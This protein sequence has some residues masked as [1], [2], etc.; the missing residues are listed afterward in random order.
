LPKT[1][2]DDKKVTVISASIDKTF[3]EKADRII[4]ERLLPGINNRSALI[5]Y[6]LRKVFDELFKE[7]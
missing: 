2:G 7:G 1:K 3:L 6:A 4:N 5:E